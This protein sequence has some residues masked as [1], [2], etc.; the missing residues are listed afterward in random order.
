MGEVS[1]PLARP[2]QLSVNLTLM[3]TA[4]HLVHREDCPEIGPVCQTRDE[5]PQ[6]HDQ[7]FY[8]AEL[9]PILEYGLLDGLSL[10]LQLPVRLHRSTIQFERLDGTP[11]V[12]DYESIHHRNETLFG[13][14]DPWLS[15]RG[16]WQL[17]DVRV[18]GRLGVTLPIGATVPDPF[19][20]ADEGLAHQHVQFG[21]GT[22]NPV[23]GADASRR[24]GE[25][26]LRAY[27]QAQLMLYENRYR[28]RAGNRFATGVLGT[29]PLGGGF[30]V[31]LSAD[32]VNEQPE[33][34][35][36]VIRQEG[37]LGRTDVLVGA[38]L[39]VPLGGYALTLGAK[40]PVYQHIIHVEH[41]GDHDP[42]QL[43]YPALVTFGLQRTFDLFGR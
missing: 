31:S 3:A 23:L 13:L 17:G 30:R 29:L 37:N 20:L 5:P 18:T 12:P 39:A 21:T 42:G 15:A 34:W 16:T 2:G 40:V 8:I 7:N 41:A 9:R 25:V 38:S 4:I 32:V 14:A 22:F 10:E 43:T 35:S 26:D 19:A 24:F 11:F 36:G 28:Y 6:L 27:G 1:T 33:R